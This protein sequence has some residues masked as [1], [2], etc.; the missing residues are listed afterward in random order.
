MK[1]AGFSAL[2]LPFAFA[3]FL[4][5]CVSS[6]EPPSQNVLQFSDAF[7]ASRLCDEKQEIVFEVE[8]IDKRVLCIRGEQDPAFF[9]QMET[10]DVSDV[11]VV[12]ADS[13]GGITRE[14]IDLV[15]DIGVNE[16][17]LVIR[18]NCLSSCANYLFVGARRKFLLSGAKIGWHG[19]EDG[20]R[21]NFLQAIRE[22]Y[23]DPDW[24]QEEEDIAQFEKSAARYALAYQK[25]T[26][27]YSIQ[28]VSQHL[29]FDH[30]DVARCEL[31]RLE[32]LQQLVKERHME[33]SFFSPS[34][35][36]L[37]E[38]YGVRDI[39]VDVPEEFST[40]IMYVA[41]DRGRFEFHEVRPECL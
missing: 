14:T 22:F 41:D 36:L 27:L 7:F 10:V 20:S 11:S 2:I 28:N 4:A 17:D 3:L 33:R 21:E 19:G 40:S 1:L 39:F 35:D 30:H 12:V 8:L 31:E 38:K 25:Q 9:R 5:G 34:L 29:M 16:Y 23:D 26:E 15:F 6:K 24:P 18:K 32:V 13:N 37:H